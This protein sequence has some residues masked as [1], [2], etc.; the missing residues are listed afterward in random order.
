MHSPQPPN[1][2][3]LF[4]P[5]GIRS[6]GSSSSCFSD[7]RR[8]SKVVLLSPPTWELNFYDHCVCDY[9]ILKSTLT[10]VL[11]AYWKCTPAMCYYYKVFLKP[12]WVL[13]LI[14][15]IITQTK[16]HVTENKQWYRRLGL[17]R[18]A[19]KKQ[20]LSWQLL[21]L[22]KKLICPIFCLQNHIVPFP[23]NVL[24][25]TLSTTCTSTWDS[26]YEIFYVWRIHTLLWSY[27]FDQFDPRTVAPDLAHQMQWLH[28]SFEILG[29][30]VAKFKR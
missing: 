7:S 29:I 11:F 20:E 6:A 8:S 24:F 13:F 19:I 17:L 14:N 28:C 10:T 5:T 15:I 3:S 16:L 18:K 26:C 4:S 12:S 22:D 1:F 30:P 9:I 2:G 23:R 27:L 21:I 25:T